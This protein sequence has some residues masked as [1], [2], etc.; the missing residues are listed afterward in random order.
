MIRRIIEGRVNVSWECDR[1][2]KDD[3]SHTRDAFS[4][5][6]L[7][8]SR[9]V[10]F[11][12]A[13]NPSIDFPLNR[14]TLS[15]FSVQYTGT[16]TKRINLDFIRHGWISAWLPFFLAFPTLDIFFI[17]VKRKKRK[18][19]TLLE[20]TT[21]KVTDL[22]PY[23]WIKWFGLEVWYNIKEVIVVISASYNSLQLF[24]NE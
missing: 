18:I 21:L 17:C 12:C 2:G 24:F 16:V 10:R 22:L 7:K 19:S 14:P 15:S 20:K 1:S 13:R 6:V 4:R 3:R 8:V 9:P 5:D 23:G 11:L